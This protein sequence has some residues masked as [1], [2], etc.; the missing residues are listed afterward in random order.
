MTV[1]QFAESLGLGSGVSGFVYHT[2]PVAIFGWFTHY[3][4]VAATLDSVVKCGGDTDSAGAIAGALAGAAAGAGGI[5]PEYLDRLFE[6]PYSVQFLRRLGTQLTRFSKGVPATVVPAAYWAIPFRN[7]LF[8]G[9]VF[10]HVLGRLLIF[11]K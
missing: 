11:W 2:V 9:T 1:A 10:A 4:D 6:F 8:T 7:L 3:G 5:P